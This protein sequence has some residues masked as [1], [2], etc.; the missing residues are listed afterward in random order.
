VPNRPLLLLACAALLSPLAAQRPSLQEIL[1]TTGTRTLAAEARKAG[2]AQRGAVVF[3]QRAVQCTRCHVPDKQNYR[4]GPDL[5]KFDREVSDEHLVE[6]V[7]N[8]SAYVREGY[9]TV[10]VETKT[11][12]LS[13]FLVSDTG[14]QVVIRDAARNYKEVRIDKVEDYFKTKTS[15]MPTGLVNLLTSKQ[16]FLDL[17]RYLIEIRDGGSKRALALEPDPSLYADRPLPEYEADIDHAGFIRGLDDAAF[18]RGRETYERVCINCHGTR[19][20]VG[21]LPSALRFAEGKFKNGSDPYTMYQT[22]TRGFGMMTAQTWMV[23]SQKYDVV[24]YIREEYLKK[25]NPTQ[26]FEVDDRYLESLPKGKSRGPKPSPVAVW[27]RMDYG[28]NQTLTLEIGNDG[29]NF[30]YKGNAVRLDAGPG[31]VAEGRYWMIFDTDTMRVAAAWHGKGFIDWNCIHFNGRHAVHPRLVGELAVANPTGPGWGRPG[32]GSFAEVRLVGRDNRRYGPLPRDWAKYRGMYYHG[33]D[34]IFEY[35]VGKTRVLEMPAVQVTKPRAIFQRVLNIGAREH[36]LVV[37]VAHSPASGAKLTVEA[38]VAVFG[39]PAA[40]DDTAPK[41]ADASRMHGRTR[42]AVE[43]TTGLHAGHGDF[44][45]TAR[46]KTKKDG[47]IVAQTGP[48]LEWIHDGLSWFVRG[49]RLTIDIGWVGAFRGRTRVADGRW[50]DVAVTYRQDSGEIRF[51]VDGVAEKRT[52]T[53]RRK[54]AVDKSVVRIGFTSNRFPRKSY[55]DG[56]LVE[57]RFFNEVLGEGEIAG[58]ASGKPTATMP[59]A[60]W[61]LCKLERGR[62]ADLASHRY[63]ASVSTAEAVEVP[64]AVEGLTVAGVEGQSQGLRWSATGGDLR[65]TI[66]AGPARRL[67]LWFATVEK[68]GDVAAVRDTVVIDDPAQ[69]LAAKTK[70]GPQRWPYELATEA[71][72]GRDDGPFAVDVVKRPTDNPWFCRL[73]MTGFDFTPDGKSMIASSWDGS[74]WKITGLDKLPAN[75]SDRASS[76]VELTWRRIASGLFQPL[77]VKVVDGEIYVTCRDQLARLHDQ[78]GDGEI[79]W[80]ECFNG[81][82]QVTDHFHEFAMGLQ[83]DADGNFYYAKSARH[84]LPALVPQHGTL[85]R[86]SKDGSRTDIVAF[87]FRAANGVCVNPDGTFIVTDQE[88]HWTPKNRINYVKPG[89]FYGNMLGYHNVTDSSDDAMEQPIVWITNSF[90]RSPA[91]PLW[92]D[93]PKWG[94][95]NKQLLNLSYGYGM[96]YVVPFE[97]VGGQEQGGVCALPIERFPTGVMRGRFHAGDGQLYLA[98]MFGWAGNQTQPG[99]VYRLR[100]TGKPFYLPIELHATKRGM[101]VKLSGRLEREEATKPENYVVK[102]WSLKRTKNYGSKHYNEHELRVA[103]VRLDADDQTV[104]IDLPDIAP[105]WCMEIRYRI[106][107]AEGKPIDGKIHN[108]IHRLLNP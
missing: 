6:S 21:S 99:G 80:V 52:G 86:V 22:L 105:T 20:E 33:P 89:R 82:H 71:I 69:D 66:P 106:R 35:T 55:F 53:L 92:V 27:Q 3:Y 18:R 97:R 98:G 31:G 101:T 47:T 65:L 78:N 68:P 90:D 39:A 23:P 103:G 25:H 17:V 7:L 77:G 58:L 38:G 70:G 1:E 32:D 83:T 9:E 67:T 14:K 42:L 28:P 59:K 62:V 37:Q 29:T 79:D 108:T 96:V 85:L 54:Q 94:P 49:G 45:L 76:K 4:L 87:G 51:F 16:Q 43:D 73:R 104:H 19:T 36:D 41:T 34:T 63:H 56:Q 91:E 10:V 64:G 11:G 61:D 84:A 48:G 8:P 75:G 12:S 100:Y 74:V 24:H 50:H 102:V 72:I 44:T 107:S 46:I 81:D 30:A 15:A 2:D 95:L 60:R 26:Y 93:S 57:V 13:G 40:A 5:A 88:G